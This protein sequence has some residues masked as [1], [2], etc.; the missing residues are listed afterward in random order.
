MGSCF[1]RLDKGYRL[2]VLRM[3]RSQNTI[4]GVTCSVEWYGSDLLRNTAC[5]GTP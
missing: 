1:V 4:P 5:G 3:K 2:G